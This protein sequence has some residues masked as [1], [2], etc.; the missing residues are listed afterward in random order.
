MPSSSTDQTTKSSRRFGKTSKRVFTFEDALESYIRITAKSSYTIISSMKSIANSSS[1]PKLKAREGDIVADDAVQGLRGQ[2]TGHIRK[3]ASGLDLRTV[4]DGVAAYVVVKVCFCDFM[5][6]REE[7]LNYACQAL[8]PLRLPLSIWLTPM[9]V[10][11]VS[12]AT[13]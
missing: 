2:L 8:F 12:R 4:V 3:T 7:M 9:F 5:I 6:Q 10:R 11:A 1:N 13:K